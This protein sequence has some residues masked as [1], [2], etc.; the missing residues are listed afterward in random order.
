MHLNEIILVYN[1]KEIYKNIIFYK[2]N[3]LFL[4]KTGLDLFR[5]NKYN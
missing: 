1:E 4:D 3:A 5:G 2:E